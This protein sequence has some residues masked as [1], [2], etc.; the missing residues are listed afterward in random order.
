MVGLAVEWV[1]KQREASSQRELE[2]AA[3]EVNILVRDK[4]KR[5][6]INNMEEEKSCKF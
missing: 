1:A 6:I 2:A 3:A 5:N 4:G